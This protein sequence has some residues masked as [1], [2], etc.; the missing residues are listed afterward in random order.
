MSPSS[1]FDRHCSSCTA[2]TAAAAGFDCSSAAAAAAPAAVCNMHVQSVRGCRDAAA[3]LVTSDAFAQ[4][5]VLE[6]IGYGINDNKAK[7][8]RAGSF[9]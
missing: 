2:L 7:I 8:M 1:V 4:C 9:C 3:D 6:Y 5:I